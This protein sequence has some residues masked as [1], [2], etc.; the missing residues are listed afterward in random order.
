MALKIFGQ[1]SLLA[2]ARALSFPMAALVCAGLGAL[3]RETPAVAI[4]L[5]AAI[6]AAV[7]VAAFQRVRLERQV[8]AL[9]GDALSSG[10]AKTVPALASRL[11]ALALREAHAHPVTGLPTRERLNEAVATDIAAGVPTALLGVIRFVDYDRGRRD[12]P[13]RSR[14]FRGLVRRRRRRGGHARASGD[15]LCRGQE[16]DLDET[17]L[18]PVLEIGLASLSARRADG[19]QLILRATATLAR[20]GDAGYRPTRLPSPSRPER[21]R[22]VLAGAGSGPGHRRKPAD[23]GLPAGRGLARRPHDR[24]RGPAALGPPAP[25]RGVARQVH[26]DCRGPWALASATASGC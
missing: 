8:A 15:R 22:A 3:S 10:L 6:L 16:I 26:P 5:V 4:P 24:R 18:S 7:V 25:W 17:V 23:H 9:S 13:D 14:L 20:P 21:A 12:R 1:T 11:Q 19:A 2:Q